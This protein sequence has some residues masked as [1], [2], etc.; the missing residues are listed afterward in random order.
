MS[1]TF[2]TR[3]LRLVVLLLAQM[4]IFN[5]VHLLGYITP[6]VI[7]Y[8]LVCFH[9]STPHVPLL[10]WGFATGLLF[11]MV[12]NTAGMGAASCTL[13][14]M[15]QPSLLRFFTPRNA[16]EEF[17]PTL[18]ALGLWHYTFYVF[19]LMLILHGAFYLL[20]AFTLADWLLTLFS[21]LGGA[22]LTTVFILF[23]ELLV[24]HKR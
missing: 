11:D 6:L 17:T 9:R 2:L 16:G 5:Q 13:V 8:M 14:A 22:L 18:Q 3:L 10:L 20:D 7:G 4:L 24:R 1:F 12:S 23:I 15:V 19:L 21:A